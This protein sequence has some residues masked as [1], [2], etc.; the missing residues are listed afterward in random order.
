MAILRWIKKNAFILLVAFNILLFCFLIIG[1]VPLLPGQTNINVENTAYGLKTAISAYFTD[2]RHF[3]IEN[4]SL[5]VTID[6][7]HALMDILLASGPEAKS[8][9]SPRKIVFF[10]GKNARQLKDGRFVMGVAFDESGGGELWDAWGNYYRIRMDTNFDNQVENPE[11]PG[12][13]VSDPILVWSA[14]KDGKFETWKNNVK[15]WDWKNP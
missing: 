6:S 12:Q 9:M 7:K 15:T 8:G 2:Y 4:K 14:G 11:V 5:D 13:F 1:A 3:P 10:N